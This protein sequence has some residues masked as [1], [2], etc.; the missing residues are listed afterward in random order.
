MP[1]PL[2]EIPTVRGTPAAIAAGDTTKQ[3]MTDRSAADIRA[4]EHIHGDPS[5]MYRDSD[6]ER[7][8]LINR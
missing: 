3:A 8:A 2:S 6:G 5:R 7:P 4:K 1:R